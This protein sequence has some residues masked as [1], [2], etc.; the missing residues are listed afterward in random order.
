MLP[1]TEALSKDMN[2]CCRY[3]SHLQR[4]QGFVVSFLV[5]LHH[6]TSAL[7]LHH[8]RCLTDAPR[9]CN[10]NASLHFGCS[11][12]LILAWIYTLTTWI[13]NI[14]PTHTHRDNFRTSP[15]HTADT[16]KNMNQR[17]PAVFLLCYLTTSS[18]P[19]C[20]GTNSNTAMWLTALPRFPSWK[21][22]PNCTAGFSNSEETQPIS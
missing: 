6:T 4:E 10:Q 21:L 14:P 12:S 22:S 8:L 3:C 11:L 15:A 5:P 13:F 18:Y 19:Q 1:V 2:L 20:G 17:L 16:L 7:G 9:E